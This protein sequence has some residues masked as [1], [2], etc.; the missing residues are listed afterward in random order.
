[1]R[2]FLFLL[3][4]VPSV[5]SAQSLEWLA[6]HPGM[7]AVSMGVASTTI[8]TP[9]TTNEGLEQVVRNAFANTPVMAEIARCESGFRQF[10]ARGNALDG[11]SGG[12]IGLFQINASVHAAY[13]KS[14]G[15][16]I[17]S[18]DG[19]LAY[20]RKLY[21]EEGTGPWLSSFSCWHANALP[22]TD[23]STSAGPI[24]KDLILG[25]IDPQVLK[26]QKLLNS[27]GFMIATDG[28]GSPGQET[29]KFG[30]LTREAVR[31]FQCA[32]NITCAGDEHTS[33]F[34]F[35]GVSTRAALASLAAANSSSNPP[36]PPQ[37]EAEQIA[38]LQRQIEQLTAQ[39]FAL[40][41]S[42]AMR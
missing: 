33:G 25:V 41:Q 39:I 6:E 8:E 29:S 37:S 17:Y 9:R 23:S 15:M 22:E 38:A 27:S 5:V 20:A 14:I 18:V 2:I 34:G 1:M 12:M 42:I 35:V 30:L 28:P 31:R 4:C 16:N 10:D 40:K 32:K 36:V 21:E 11:G 19:N 26:L 24:T 13:A 7:T 3:L